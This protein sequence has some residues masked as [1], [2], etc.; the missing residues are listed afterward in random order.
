MRYCGLPKDSPLPIY[1]SVGSE[2]LS[3]LASSVQTLNIPKISKDY[4][5]LSL[6]R[7]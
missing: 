3:K 2:Y 4:F 1:L 6:N 5:S 7:R